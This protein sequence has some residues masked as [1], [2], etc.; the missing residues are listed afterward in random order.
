MRL[1]R[2]SHNT[3]A[4]IIELDW[5]LRAA[6]IGVP[7]IA[8]ELDLSRTRHGILQVASALGMGKARRAELSEPPL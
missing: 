4:L 2:L 7:E 5:D 8:S 1:A 6:P 3:C